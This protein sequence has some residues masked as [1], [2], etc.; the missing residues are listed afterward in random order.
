MLEPITIR[1]WKYS[2]KLPARELVRSPGSSRDRGGNEAVGAFGA[3]G[4]V[5]TR[6]AWGE[7]QRV[8]TPVVK[9]DRW[10]QTTSGSSLR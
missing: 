4:H 6:R 1:L 8:T 5:M 9:K 7:S 3:E 10:V 2:C